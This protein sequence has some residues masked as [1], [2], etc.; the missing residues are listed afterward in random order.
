MSL[1]L[2]SEL[3]NGKWMEMK[4]K[5]MEMKGKWMEVKGKWMKRISKPLD[6]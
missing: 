1:V 3:P 2:L 4:G 6:H 5:W